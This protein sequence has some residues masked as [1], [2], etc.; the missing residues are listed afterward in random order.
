MLTNL[1]VLFFSVSSSIFLLLSRCEIAECIWTFQ[2]RSH[3]Y[4]CKFDTLVLFDLRVA[5][6][7]LELHKVIHITCTLHITVTSSTWLTGIRHLVVRTFL[8]L[9]RKGCF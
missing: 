3:C 5:L 4:L 2:F 6:T 7:F 8:L 1:D 9:F